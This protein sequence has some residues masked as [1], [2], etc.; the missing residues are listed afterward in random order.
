MNNLSKSFVISQEKQ[1]LKDLSKN[2]R[3]VKKFLKETQQKASY[4]NSENHR[5][6]VIWGNLS[7]GYLETDIR[8]LKFEYRHLHI[9]YCLF[10]GRKYEQIENKTKNPPDMKYIHKLVGEL[11]KKLNRLTIVNDGLSLK[12]SNEESLVEVKKYLEGKTNQKQINCFYWGIDRS[13]CSSCYEDSDEELWALY[14]DYD[15]SLLKREFKK[16]IKE[17]PIY[18]TEPPKMSNMCPNFLE[19]ISDK[20][21]CRY[22]HTN[23]QSWPYAFDDCDVSKGDLLGK[24]YNLRDFFIP[25][26]MF[27]K[28]KYSFLLEK[29]KKLKELKDLE[30]QEEKRKEEERNKISKE[31]YEKQSKYEEYLELKNKVGSFSSIPVVEKPEVPENLK[32]KVF[33]GNFRKKVVL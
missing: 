13:H 9:A 21:L 10:R 24:A 11:N 28:E 20:I 32:F 16:F 19:K 6:Q 22:Q 33:V 1:K 14:T 18:L 31:Y 26:K 7:P 8:N 17:N 5:R 15:F 4:I 30:A 2:I 27:S 29:G 12:M 23:G 25:E 3:I